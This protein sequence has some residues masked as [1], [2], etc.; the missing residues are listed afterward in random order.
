MRLEYCANRKNWGNSLNVSF[1]ESGY[2]LDGGR[3]LETSRENL[4]L[5][6]K[7]NEQKNE[8]DFGSFVVREI[9]GRKRK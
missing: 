7:M 9:V 5:A 3:G 6:S 8:G 2:I 4:T 1:M